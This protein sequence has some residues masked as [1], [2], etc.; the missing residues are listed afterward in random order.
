MASREI[1]TGKELRE[2]LAQ[3]ANFTLSAPSI[4]ALM[5]NEPVQ[6]KT[7]TLQALCTALKCT[8]NELYGVTPPRE[9]SLADEPDTDDSPASR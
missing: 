4:S 6:M 8:P 7:E 9:I 1:W 3:R 5:K 2:L